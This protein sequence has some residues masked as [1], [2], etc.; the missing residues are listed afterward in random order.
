MQWAA[1]GHELHAAAVELGSST[2]NKFPLAL[3]DFCKLIGC[4]LMRDYLLTRGKRDLSQRP[5]KEILDKIDWVSQFILHGASL[6]LAWHH[7]VH[8]C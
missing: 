1:A 7:G 5:G 2:E 3:G 8:A 4:L 6:F